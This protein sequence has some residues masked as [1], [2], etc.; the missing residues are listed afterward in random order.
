MD[1]ESKEFTEEEI[2]E[3]KEF[4]A[5]KEPGDKKE[6]KKSSVIWEYVRL[7]IIVVAA[8]F[9]LL[10]FVVINAQ[11]PSQSMEHT[12]ND[13]DRIFGFRLA[14]AFGDPA[15]YDIVIFK[16]P[17]SPD[18]LYIKRIIGLPGETVVVSYGSVYVIDSSVVTADIDDEALI[19]DP[20]LLGNATLT[21]T[22]FSPEPQNSDGRDNGV[23]R[24]P[25]GCYFMMGDNRNNSW[26]SRFWTNHYVTR[27]ALVG[28]AVFR[29]WPIT[30][31]KIL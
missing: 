2:T 9:V 19:E 22:S 1:T 28:K 10:N 7:V 8:A 20:Y 26:D 13:G 27:D 11:I 31:F 24:V 3:V 4:A 5:K 12:I 18:T 25:E 6:N 30:E 14:Y 29:Y 15:R 23:F 21:D 17:D 16:Y